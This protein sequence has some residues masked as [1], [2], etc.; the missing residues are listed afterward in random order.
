MRETYKRKLRYAE[1]RLASILSNEI[2]SEKDI[3]L[4]KEEIEFFS[5]QLEYIDAAEALLHS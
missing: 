3:N 2:V 4:R 1:G 5:K